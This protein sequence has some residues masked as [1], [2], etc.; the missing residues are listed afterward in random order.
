MWV[1]AGR[2]RL[3]SSNLKNRK[4]KDF[5]TRHNSQPKLNGSSALPS[6]KTKKEV[7]TG[8]DLGRGEAKH[9]CTKKSEYTDWGATERRKETECCN[10]FSSLRWV[11]L[12]RRRQQ[13]NSATRQLPK[14]GVTNNCIRILRDKFENGRRRKKAFEK[15]G[16]NKWIDRATS[17]QTYGEMAGQKQYCR[18]A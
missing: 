1:W 15:E 3:V 17:I 6:E 18:G 11:Q 5:P 7:Q 13:G 14:D 2:W 8:T 10:R 16:F 12:H 9:R 4:G